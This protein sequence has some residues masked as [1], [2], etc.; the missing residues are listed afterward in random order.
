MNPVTESMTAGESG[1]AVAEDQVPSRGLGAW[2][3]LYLPAT[4]N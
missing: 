4:P 2:Q 3:A 1:T